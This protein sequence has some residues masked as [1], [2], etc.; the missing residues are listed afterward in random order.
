MEAVIIKVT[1]H[2]LGIV[3][4]AGVWLVPARL[5]SIIVERGIGSPHT[6]QFRRIVFAVPVL[7]AIAFSLFIAI[8]S[9]PRVLRCLWE[10]WCTATQGG[11]LFNLAL[12]GAT[13]LLVEAVRFVSRAILGRWGGQQSP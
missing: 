8:D 5:Y 4:M 12:F 13:V 2:V 7:I 9:I 6:S 3:G 10:Q 1:A 11:G